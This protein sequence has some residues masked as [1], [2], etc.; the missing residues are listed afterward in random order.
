MPR[1]RCFGVREPIAI[2]YARGC[3]PVH[4]ESLTPNRGIRAQSSCLCNPS[5]LTPSGSSYLTW[6]SSASVRRENA[7]LRN[8]IGRAKAQEV[9]QSAGNRRRIA[10]Y[11][12]DTPENA[13][14]HFGG[15][16]GFNP[17]GQLR[18]LDLRHRAGP[19]GGFDGTGA[20]VSSPVLQP[21]L[22]D[23]FEGVFRGDHDNGLF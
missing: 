2:Q 18:W 22:G 4:E 8:C 14:G 11:H 7:T 16:S 15:T 6:A 5:A 19:K 21:S 17:L 12:T 9:L 1:S 10:Q 20:L 13:L 23:L 3:N